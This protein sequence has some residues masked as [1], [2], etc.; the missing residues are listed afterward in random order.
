MLGL[1]SSII[2][3]TFSVKGDP[4]TTN[5]IKQTCQKELECPCPASILP[6]IATAYGVDIS[7]V[8][9]DSGTQTYYI[10]FTGPPSF[11]VDGTVTFVDC[12]DCCTDIY[13]TLMGYPPVGPI[14]ILC[15]L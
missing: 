12:G 9:Y 5:K 6:Y 8:F 14:H 3:G 11:N 13:L 7:Q 10:R 1:V 4:V 15:D 2:A